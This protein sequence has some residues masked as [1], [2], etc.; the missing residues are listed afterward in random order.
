[1]PASL[2][3]PQQRPA[4]SA[5]V[6]VRM[7]AVVAV[8]IPLLGAIITGAIHHS[9]DTS[10]VSISSSS[11]GSPSIWA[12]KRNPLNTYFAKLAW[13]WTTVVYVAALYSTIS[14]RKPLAVI[15]SFLR[16]AAAT[17]Y[18]I[19]MT[20]WFFGPPLFDRL[21]VRT[22]GRCAFSD[23][24]KAIGVLSLHTCRLEGGVWEGGHDVSGHCFLLLHSALFLAEDVLVPLL[25]IATVR[26]QST[27]RRIT[28]LVA[29]G[30]IFV[31]LLMLYFTAKYFHGPRE[32]ISGALLGVCCWL[33]VYQL[34]LSRSRA[35]SSS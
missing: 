7:R 26:Q 31:W 9:S 5:A 3:S 23:E 27:T 24:R 30:L 8:L 14:V 33:P 28:A 1:M 12:N 25:T 17:M 4:N 32:L 6:V 19:A 18:W 29:G 22:G 20:Q 2:H 34:R 16:Y 35:N 10:N 15:A 11:S 21:F 13:A